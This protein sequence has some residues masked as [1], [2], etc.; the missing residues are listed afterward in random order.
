MP[1]L[2][3]DVMALSV[4][5]KMPVTA[6]HTDWTT[7]ST[8][9]SAP[10]TKALIWSKYLKTSAAAIPTGPSRSPTINRP[11]RRHERENPVDRPEDRVLHGVE[12]RDARRS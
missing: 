2:T 9:L 3:V 11:V 8:A 10:D 4:D 1:P 12:G 6:A 7:P 5:E